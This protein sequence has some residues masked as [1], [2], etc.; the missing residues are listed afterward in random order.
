MS[1]SSSLLRIEPEQLQSALMAG[2]SHVRTRRELLNRINV[3]PVPDGDTGTNLM[4]TLNSVGERLGRRRRRRPRRE[5]SRARR[6]PAQQP[7][8]VLR[9]G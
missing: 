7:L 2:I 6:I 1:V 5:L 3:F 4:F 9:P 8:A